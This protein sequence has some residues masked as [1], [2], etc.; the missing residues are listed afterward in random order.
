MRKGTLIL[1]IIISLIGGFL[2]MKIQT[3]ISEGNETITNKDCVIFAEKITAP[4]SMIFGNGV[5]KLSW[6]SG[7]MKFEGDVDESAKIFFEYLKSYVDEYI[8]NKNL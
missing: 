4:T 7:T 6:G 2:L 3:G 8:N 5:G 1:I